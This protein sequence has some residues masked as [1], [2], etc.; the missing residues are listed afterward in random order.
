MVALTNE[1][2]G[3]LDI[4]GIATTSKAFSQTHT[5]DRTLGV[6]DSCRITVTWNRDY[7]DASLLITDNGVGSPQ[8]VDLHGIDY[9]PR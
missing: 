1:G 7:A 8:T 2:P 3:K 6:G 4:R 9:C 5:C